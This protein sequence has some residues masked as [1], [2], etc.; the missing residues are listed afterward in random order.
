MPN[1][2]TAWLG[3]CKEAIVPLLGLEELKLISCEPE[4]FPFLL[5]TPIRAAVVVILLR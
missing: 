4:V 1:N 2:T 3:G 5:P